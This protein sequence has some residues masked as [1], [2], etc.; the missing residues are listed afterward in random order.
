MR[1]NN[2]ETNSSDLTIL[3]VSLGANSYF[4][5][6]KLTALNLMPSRA[7][8]YIGKRW[9]YYCTCHFSFINSAFC[10]ARFDWR[11]RIM[12][13]TFWYLPIYIILLLLKMLL[14]SFVSLGNWCQLLNLCQSN[15]A[16]YK[17]VTSFIQVGN[18]TCFNYINL[19]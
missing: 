7:T 11:T 6:T 13:F 2:L 5:Q 9:Q 17:Y 1:G 15:R 12:Y 18:Q 19:I 16:E 4:S 3:I 8:G 14:L 10:E